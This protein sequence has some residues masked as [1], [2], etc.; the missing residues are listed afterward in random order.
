M[1]SHSPGSW[2]LTK[3]EAEMCIAETRTIPSVMPAAARQASTSSVMSMISW[4]FAV[5]EGP[6][7][8][9][10]CAW[11]LRSRVVALG[12]T[13]MLPRNLPPARP[14]G[15]PVKQVGFRARLFLILLGFAL[16]PTI[17]LRRRGS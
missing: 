14:Y 13:C 11:R 2:S 12:A 8:R 10:E 3:T 5:L 4:R 16:I 6:I 17:V 9:C 7:G 15:V 1:S